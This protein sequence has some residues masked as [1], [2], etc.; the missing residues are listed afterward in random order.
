MRIAKAGFPQGVRAQ[1]LSGGVTLITLPLPRR[2]RAS[3]LFKTYANIL[4]AGEKAAFSRI[5]SPR[6]RVSYIAGRVLIRAALSCY[7]GVSARNI[8]PE[9][10]AGGKPS[11]RG[12]GGAAFS[13][14]HTDGLAALA[15]RR[16]G[17]VGVDAE[18]A[19]RRMPLRLPESRYLHSLERNIL[20]E[21][22]CQKEQARVFTRIWIAKEA[23]LKMTGDGLAYGAGRF[24]ALPDGRN[25]TIF[26][27]DM[28]ARAGTPP[29][30]VLTYRRGVAIMTVY[31]RS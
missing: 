1:K 16:G 17:A 29:A 10:A 22:S 13:L 11:A 7:S 20:T 24:A 6:R 2:P 4:T 30:A 3:V 31:V 8:T 15:L 26:S 28:P 25:G 5:T 21:L 19:Q 23:L 27:G 18:P 9:Y 14:A 12:A